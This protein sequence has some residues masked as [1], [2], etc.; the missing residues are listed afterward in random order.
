MHVKN[1]MRH[2]TFATSYMLQFDVHYEKFHSTKPHY[3]ATK[4]LKKTHI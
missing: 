3:L 2:N 4:T 1:S